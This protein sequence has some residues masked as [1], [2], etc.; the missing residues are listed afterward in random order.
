MREPVA[1]VL[2]GSHSTEPSLRKS[3]RSIGLPVLQM[4]EPS[5]W[6]ALKGCTTFPAVVDA[7]VDCFTLCLLA[8]ASWQELTDWQRLEIENVT[9]LSRCFLAAGPN[10]GLWCNLLLH[11]NPPKE[12]QE[13][14]ELVVS[15]L[16]AS[17]PVPTGLRLK[18]SRYGNSHILKR[19]VAE[20]QETAFTAKRVLVLV[21]GKWLEEHNSSTEPEDEERRQVFMALL[22][23]ELI[24]NEPASVILA[25]KTTAVGIPVD[26]FAASPSLILQN[27]RFAAFFV[28]TFFQRLADILAK[29][30]DLRKEIFRLEADLAK[31]RDVLDDSE[32]E[33]GVALYEVTEQDD[34]E[35]LPV[36]L[37]FYLKDSEVLKAAHVKRATARAE[38][39]VCSEQLKKVTTLCGQLA[40]CCRLLFVLSSVM[41]HTLV[42]ERALEFGQGAE[43]EEAAR[44][45]LIGYDWDKV[46]NFGLFERRAYNTILSRLFM[47]CAA[48]CFPELQDI[49]AKDG[50]LANA[51]DSDDEGTPVLCP[52]H[53]AMKDLCSPHLSWYVQVQQS[54]SQSQEQEGGDDILSKKPLLLPSLDTRIATSMSYW[55]MHWNL[56]AQ[57]ALLGWKGGKDKSMYWRQLVKKAE[58]QHPSMGHASVQNSDDVDGDEHQLQ[59]DNKDASVIS[60]LRTARPA[61]EEEEDGGQGSIYETAKLVESAVVCGFHSENQALLMADALL[62]FSGMEGSGLIHRR[63]LHPLDILQPLQSSPLFSLSEDAWVECVESLVAIARQEGQ[64]RGKDRDELRLLAALSLLSVL[65]QGASPPFKFPSQA[66]TFQ[67]LSFTPGAGVPAVES[68]MS[69]LGTSIDFLSQLC[70]AQFIYAGETSNLL[71]IG[72]SNRSAFGIALEMLTAFSLLGDSATGAMERAILSAAESTTSIKWSIAEKFS[73][74]ENPEDKVLLPFLLAV[75]GGTTQV[76]KFLF[77]SLASAS[78]VWDDAVWAAAD[79]GVPLLRRTSLTFLAAMVASCPTLSGMISRRENYLAGVVVSHLSTLNSSWPLLSLS[80]KRPETA[81]WEWRAVIDLANQMLLFAL[82]LIREAKKKNATASS[83]YQTPQNVFLLEFGFEGNGIISAKDLNVFASRGLAEL[84]RNAVAN[85]EWERFL[86]NVFIATL[87]D[88]VLFTL[89]LFFEMCVGRPEV[90]DAIHQF[91][92]DL[93]KYLPSHLKA[94]HIGTAELCCRFITVLCTRNDACQELVLTSGCVEGMMAALSLCSSSGNMDRKF[95]IRLSGR[96]VEAIQQLVLRSQLAWKYVQD[97]S[98][99]EGLLQLCELGNTTIKNLCCTTLMEQSADWDLPDFGNDVTRKGG[100]AVFAPLLDAKEAE[101]THNCCL[102]LLYTLCINSTEFRKESFSSSGVILF[103][104]VFALLRRCKEDSIRI[105]I[106]NLLSGYGAENPV[107]LR[108]IMQR[109]NEA[110]SI[111]VDISSGGGNVILTTAAVAAL[112]CMTTFDDSEYPTGT[113]YLRQALHASGTLPSLR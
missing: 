113:A 37:S 9:K 82:T 88:T 67:H 81:L 105:L 16:A 86:L 108:K 85:N 43:E 72:P 5:Y 6:G 54:R 75:G 73:K 65:V 109:E 102:R 68:V 59:Q 62:T 92:K 25:A 2:Q 10:D 3:S 32:H 48:R 36:P 20:L 50:V 90:Q 7:S 76:L 19:R 79:L 100:I 46:L 66:P 110:M 112:A 42:F 63:G 91:C 96:I 34:E 77:E 101:S 93:V 15:T 49:F 78:V 106:C 55:G 51:Y 89:E 18:N 99:I 40:Q 26:I 58:Q 13:M 84:P 57:S 12:V 35:Y 103:A 70:A 69:T 11:M 24:C 80:S 98:G 38:V 87:R 8:R 104:A 64:K 14:L 83:Y 39:E 1:C 97:C 56:P 22:K 41:T 53:L 28:G 23:S 45:T 111:I 27:I 17:V 30:F 52:L 94:D 61:V 31:L 74:I 47:T 107:L 29:F 71:P 60:Y 44:Q 4:E 21:I 95:A 33:W